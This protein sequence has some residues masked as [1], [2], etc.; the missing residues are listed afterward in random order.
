MHCG[1]SLASPISCKVNY[2]C[3]FQINNNNEGTSP[4]ETLNNLLGAQKPRFTS[5]FSFDLCTAFIGTVVMHHNR[6]IYE[7]DYTRHSKIHRSVNSQ[8][9]FGISWIQPG[10]YVIADWDRVLLLLFSI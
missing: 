6:R 2:Y 8:I 10:K 1:V 4:V 9:K 5:R 3:Y 7:K